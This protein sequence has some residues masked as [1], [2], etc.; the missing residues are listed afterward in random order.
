MDFQAINFITAASMIG[1]GISMGLGATGAALGEGYSAQNATIAISQR[2]EMA[3]E[4]M[5]NMLIGQA[6]AES[7]AIF[8]LVISIL[9]I[10]TNA[11]GDSPLCAFAMLSAGIC[12]GLGSIGAGFGS[13]LP[14]GAACE[15]LVRQPAMSSQISTN[16]LLGSAVCQ[17]PAIFALVVSFLIILKNYSALPVWPTWAGILAAGL[18][19]GLGSFGS[20]VGGGVIARAGSTGVARQPGASSSTSALMLIAQSVT[21]TP[22]IYATLISFLLL[23]KSY[24]PTQTLTSAAALLGAG[25]AMGFGANGP[26]LGIGVAGEKA[27]E[28]VAKTSSEKAIL[29]RTMLI[30]QAVSESTAI[31]SM[32]VAL[33]LIFVI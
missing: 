33:V 27:V 2:P 32:V 16:M 6:M 11:G 1:A 25:L 8:A 29:T 15:S 21:Q 9:L 30:G 24:T 22:V 13:G 23:F 18:C 10:F 12:M 4:V 7:A 17:T 26:A 20:G 31:Y 5:K 19:T 3:G 14:A 28:W